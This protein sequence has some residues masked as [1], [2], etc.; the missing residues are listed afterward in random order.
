MARNSIYLPARY[1]VDLRIS[2]FMRARRPVPRRSDRGVQERVE[3]AADRVAATAILA[4]NAA[5]ELPNGF[6]PTSADDLTPPTG[7]EQRALQIGFKL[8]F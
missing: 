3:H 7:Y 5:G 2:R 1:N 8:H 6:V 4:T